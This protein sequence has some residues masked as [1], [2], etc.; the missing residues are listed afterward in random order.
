MRIFPA[1]FFIS[2]A[3]LTA[4]A[5]NKPQISLGGFIDGYYSYNFNRPRQSMS[6]TSANNQYRY[7]DTHHNQMT[8]NLAELSI[9]A[10]YG[11]WGFLTDLD[12]GPFA[13]L[14]ATTTSTDEVSKHVGQAVISYRADGSRFFFDVGKMYT[15]LGLETVKSKDNFNYSRSILFSYGM[16]FWH[17]GARFGFDAV[18]ETLETSFYIYNGWNSLYN[19]NRS[20]TFGFQ[21]KWKASKNTTLVYNVIAGPE[22]T[23]SDG[24][25]KIVHDLNSTIVLSDST[26][27]GMNFLY[28][29]EENAPV[30]SIRRNA[31]WYGGL[32]TLKIA[33]S[34][35][36]YISPRYELYRDADG[37]TL[38]GPSQTIHSGTFTFGHMLAKH[39]EIRPELRHEKSTKSTF[40]SGPKTHQSQT[41]ALVSLLLNF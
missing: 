7:Y 24:D 18:P 3:A 25:W 34:D 16:P 36:S 1:I 19:A 21:T 5:E 30:G 13:E 39:L 14:N 12:F 29:S 33:L 38:N 2:V 23:D 28:G 17:T 22:R 27:L 4:Q 9:Q 20:H 26:T 35:K 10:K 41:T 11:E 8:L 31:I 32:A 15:H 37:Y 6:A 40:I